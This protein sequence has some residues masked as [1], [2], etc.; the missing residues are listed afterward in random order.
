M[1]RILTYAL[2]LILLT[3]TGLGVL[4]QAGEIPKGQSG[5]SYDSKPAQTQYNNKQVK[6]GE[7]I[8]VQLDL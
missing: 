4:S 2:S 7:A 6:V 8:R 3:A 5:G 1:K